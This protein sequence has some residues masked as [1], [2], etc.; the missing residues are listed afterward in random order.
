MQR[1]AMALM[2]GVGL[3]ACA[4]VEERA[5][6]SDFSAEGHAAVAR[7]VADAL[8]VSSV[9]LTSDVMLAD[10]TLVVERMRHVSD[11]GQRIQGRERGPA[12]HFHLIVKGDQCFLVHA[13]TARRWLLQNVRC[14]S[15]TSTE[16]TPDLSL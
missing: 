3:A 8:Q 9:P 13:E 14:V 4:G 1:S 11:S 2:I 15:L 6:L 12:D 16:L 10:G 7:A 5:R